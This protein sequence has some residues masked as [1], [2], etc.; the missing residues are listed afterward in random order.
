MK[1]GEPNNQTQPAGMEM[2]IAIFKFELCDN[3]ADDFIAEL[4]KMTE[5]AKT[6]DGFLGE[7]PCR[8]LI[9]ENKFVSISYWRD[10]KALIAWRNDSEHRKTQKLGKDK[11]LKWYEIQILESQREYSWKK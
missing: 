7:E 1:Q 3:V 8:S 11:F 5:R 2:I 6:M 4:N 10:K 9:N